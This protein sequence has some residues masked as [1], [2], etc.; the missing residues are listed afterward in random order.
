MLPGFRFLFA[1]IV[2]SM[3]VL[4]FGL[5]AAALLRAAHEEFASNSSLRVAPEPKFAQP[6]KRP[7]RTPK[8]RC[9]RCCGS[10]RSRRS[11]RH[12]TPAGVRGASRAT[13]NRSPSPDEPEKI[14]ALTPEDSAPPETEKPEIPV[15]GTLGAKRGSRLAADTPP[16]R[17]ARGSRRS[18][19]FCRRPIG[20]RPRA[21]AG[22]RAGCGGAPRSP[23]RRSPRW[24]VRPLRSRR[25][26][27][28]PPAPR[29]TATSSRSPPRRGAPRSAAG[30]RCARGRPPGRSQQ[31]ADPFAQPT[32]TTRSR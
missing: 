6:T 18:S 23:R 22:D 12:R 13:G 28:R 2:L 14:A 16:R 8:R 15:V 7:A 17:R 4:V 20:S 29:P 19:R 1:A 21:R 10:N 27:A 25:Q 3:S 32:I 31:A 24:A 11:R 9:W 26:P 30:R 5:G